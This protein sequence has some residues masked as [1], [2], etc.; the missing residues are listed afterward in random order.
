MDN[1]GK[2]VIVEVPVQEVAVCSMQMSN[3][4]DK[5]K[6]LSLHIANN[7]EKRKLCNRKQAQ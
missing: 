5:N 6:L 2:S 4:N 1:I 7:G 3:K